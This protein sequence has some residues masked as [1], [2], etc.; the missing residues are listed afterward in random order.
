MYF[1]P[2]T[3]Q[4]CLGGPTTAVIDGQNGMGHVIASNAMKM[5]IEKAKGLEW[6]WLLFVTKHIMAL[7]VICLDGG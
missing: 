4:S 3:I 7:P 2:V 5:A 1:D 6:E